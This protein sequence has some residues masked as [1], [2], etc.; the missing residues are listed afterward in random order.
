MHNTNAPPFIATQQPSVECCV[1]NAPR[2]YRTAQTPLVLW[3][4]CR[5]DRSLTRGVV[6][7]DQKQLT[8][9]QITNSN[10]AHPQYKRDYIVPKYG[11]PIVIYSAWKVCPNISRE[12][13]K[14]KKIPK[15]SQDKH[16]NCPVG[17]VIAESSTTPQCTTP[18]LCATNVFLFVTV[19]RFALL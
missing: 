5:M 18:V 2:A 17:Q 11:G 12:H 13:S 8:G 19:L 15:P 16:N 3:H 10:N 7:G 9:N 4:S 14:L 6:K 1:V